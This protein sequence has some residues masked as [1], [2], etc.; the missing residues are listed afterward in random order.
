MFLSSI[1]SGLDANALK[2]LKLNF[3]YSDFNC[4]LYLSGYFANVYCR[5]ANAAKNA[6]QVFFGLAEFFEFDRCAEQFFYLSQTAYCHF[7][8]NQIYFNQE[9]NSSRLPFLI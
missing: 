7:Y 6:N 3:V 4:L 8:N 1:S 5:N 9:H 2:V